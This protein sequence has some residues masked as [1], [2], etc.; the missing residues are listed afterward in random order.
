MFLMKTD[1]NLPHHI[2]AIF[3]MA[4]EEDDY[5]SFSYLTRLDESL[6][7]RIKIEGRIL[8]RYRGPRIRKPS[9]RVR[10]FRTADDFPS[11]KA[12]ALFRA[13]WRRIQSARGC[14]W[15]SSLG[16]KH[17]QALKWMQT[18]NQPDAKAVFFVQ[19]AE[20][21]LKL[22]E[23]AF[24]YAKIPPKGMVVVLLCAEISH[25]Q[26][27]RPLEKWGVR[28]LL[29]GSGYSSASN[30]SIQQIPSLHFDSLHEMPLRP[31]SLRNVDWSE[32]LSHANLIQR[33]PEK[34]LFVRPDWMKCGSATTFGKLGKLFQDRGA[35]LID[36]ALQP[37]KV[38]YDGVTI[39][40]K[41]A[42]VEND[43]A[44]SFHFNLRRGSRLHALLA[45]GTRYLSTRPKT[46]A[47]FMPIFYQ[48]CVMPDIVRKLIADARIDYL[49][50]NHYFSL[51]LAKRLRSDR[52]VFLDTHD[53]QS[54]NFVSHD[55]HRHIRMRAAPFSACLDEE[56]RF[57]DQADRVTMVSRDEI[58]LISKYRPAADL[59]YYIPIPP[60]A[61]HPLESDARKRH[62]SGES[63]A[64]TL[65]IV[66]SRNPANERSLK[67][68]LNAIWPFVAQG[69]A[70]LE[71][72]GG[73]SKSF[74]GEIFDN[75]TFRGMVEDISCAYHQADVIL[76][77]ITNGGGIAIKALE[78]IQYGKPIVATR[79]ALR[80][81]PA[82]VYDVLGGCL[83][84]Q[85]FVADLS[86][87]IA[88]SAARERR[89]KA[90]HRI[91]DILASMQ[92]DEQMHAKLDLMHSTGRSAGGEREQA[93]RIP[94]LRS[95]NSHS[96]PP[97]FQPSKAVTG[98]KKPILRHVV[99][100]PAS[101]GS[102]GDEGMVRGCLSLLTGS[103]E[104]VLLNPEHSPLWSD[105]Y[106]DEEPRGFSE[107]AGAFS[108]FYDSIT[109]NDVLIVLGADVIDGTCGLEPSLE[110]LKLVEA[111]LAAG[112]TVHIFGS[113]RSD[114][115]K[116]I[117]AH[118]RRIAG[119][120][121]YLR[122][123]HSLRR[124]RDQTGLEAEFFP[125]FFIYCP[126]KET[127]RCRAAKKLLA[128]A[129]IAGKTAIGLNFSEHAFRSFSD[130][131]D[132]VHREKYV[133]DVL[134][135]L[136][137]MVQDPYF[138][139]I[140][141]DTRCWEN[142]PSDSYYQKIAYEWLKTNGRESST[143]LLDPLVTYPEVLNLLDGLDMVISGRMHLAL[144]AFRNHVIPICLMGTGK[145]YSS[146][147]KMRGTFDKFIGR[148]ELV[149]SNTDELVL[150]VTLISDQ[151]PVLK[152]VL[153]ESLRIIEKESEEKRRQLQK[154]LGMVKTNI[155]SPPS[156]ANL[157]LVSATGKQPN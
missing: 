100:T 24:L 78:A 44:P 104:V 8:G 38:P 97:A 64:I 35:I 77:P 121:F 52:P 60:G 86:G 5:K 149:P 126:R 110:R 145:A 91:R 138:L 82:S 46:V 40:H 15:F 122:D 68:F 67:W 156:N 157:R 10:A 79:H 146:V 33:S 93:G 17:L 29:D 111:A 56:L 43:I 27:L 90:V 119:A 50:V 83:D 95:D 73:I 49:Y 71:I 11:R 123:L 32:E 147:D 70:H 42:E 87:L 4:G 57:I 45:I 114:V 59:F 25:A 30:P 155:D 103:S 101:P 51:P 148:T 28:I 88:S 124:F 113:F 36:V 140:S 48:Q 31:S 143:S 22:V 120:H 26:K 112:A 55:Y 7:G 94:S 81:L 127:D 85:D 144:A 142:F 129:R 154:K 47:G 65:L 72:V 6:G 69:E 106:A 141:N 135:T 153:E 136:C 150:A 1:S 115:H 21:G 84:E 134:A 116:E 137:P 16:A 89:S 74:V 107:C 152:E 41:L 39:Q 54:L 63:S 128:K 13:V 9:L 34:V 118:L 66:A 62:K 151:K 61:P 131:H 132:S 99:V 18:W 2:Y 20:A 80:G 58:N 75:V 37:Y 23:L 12:L 19:N 76:L 53:I 92:F 98:I 130:I 108:E 125:D 133:A 102:K 117:I 109:Q 96:T 139:L 14:Y 3:D 105:I